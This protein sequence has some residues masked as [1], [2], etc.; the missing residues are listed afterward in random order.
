MLPRHKA[1]LSRARLGAHRSAG[2]RL[3]L[4]RREKPSATSTAYG[5]HME[6]ICI[7]EQ[8]CL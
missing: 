3:L 8:F 7:P 4:E 1:G 2:K 5:S 6:T